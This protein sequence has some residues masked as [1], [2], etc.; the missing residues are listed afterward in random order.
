MNGAYGTNPNNTSIPYYPNSLA[1]TFTSFNYSCSIGT[2]VG[3]QCATCPATYAWNAGNNDCERATTPK[4]VAAT[5]ASATATA[6][7]NSLAV[8][9]VQQACSTGHLYN[10]ATATTTTTAADVGTAT[11]DNP[12]NTAGILD[13]APIPNAY[14]ELTG[15]TIANESATTRAQGTP[16][17]YNLQITQTGLLS[18]S[19]STGGAYSSVIKNQSITAS[20]GTLPASFRFGFAGSTGGSTNVHEIMC[21]KAA[22]ANTS[23]SSA[24][25]NEKQAAKVQAGTQAYFAFYNPNNWTGALTANYLIDTAGVVS[26]SPTANWDASCVLTGTASGPPR[27]AA[28]APA[29]IPADRPA[30]CRHRAIASCSPGIPKTTSA[31]LSSGPV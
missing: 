14:K 20:N 18:P 22:S 7:G 4:K 8:Q 24:T 2:V 19:Y 3:T 29:P 27:P 28:A 17:F 31:F 21:F 26:V 15:F 6:T 11:L 1:T 23:G 13:Y 25:V 10:Y 12:V 30:P 5:F 9:A 16:I